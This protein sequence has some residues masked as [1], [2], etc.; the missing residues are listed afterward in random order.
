MT[1]EMTVTVA[2]ARVSLPKNGAQ[3]TQKPKPKESS[4]WGAF[5]NLVAR[6]SDSDLSVPEAG[7]HLDSSVVQVNKPSSHS[8][9]DLL[10]A[11]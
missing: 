5:W 1:L 2:T 11:C 8:T 3:N 9:S 6:R 7:T 4:R 10:S